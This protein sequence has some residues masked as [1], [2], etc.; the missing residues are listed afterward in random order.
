MV[1]KQLWAV[2]E[3]LNK[4]LWTPML[5]LLSHSGL[6]LFL[7]LLLCFQYKTWL[8]TTSDYFPQRQPVLDFPWEHH[9]AGSNVSDGLELACPF[10]LVSLSPPQR[11]GDLEHLH[12]ICV[13]SRAL[14]PVW[15]LSA[16]PL[17]DNA[18]CEVP[19]T[20]PAP[21]PPPPCSALQGS[22]LPFLLLPSCH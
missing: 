19:L 6:W 20:H 18:V 1:V 15:H 22:W 16:F 12:L 9:A 4:E 3:L 21:P 17:H 8:T 11:L 2:D 5:G 7:F 13:G 14:A 10:L